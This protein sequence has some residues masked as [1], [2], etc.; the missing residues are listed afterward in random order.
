MNNTWAKSMALAVAVILST[1][2]CG[3]GGDGEDGTAPDEG[4]GGA[5]P[6]RAEVSAA[7]LSV[8]DLTGYDR[9]TPDPEA[10]PPDGSDKPR[11]VNALNDLDYGTPASGTAVQ[12]RAEF[13]HSALG[14]WI[15]QT[16][17]VYRDAS[18][19]EEA[20]ER[21][22]ADLSDCA[23]FTI[24]WSDLARTGTETLRETTR[25]E[26]GDRSWAADIGVE[27]G[28]FPSGETK[29]LV[30]QGRLLIVISHAGAPDAPARK[31][32]EDITRRATQRALRALDDG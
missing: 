3:G 26:L 8:D 23:R 6:T 31:D 9:I 13:G 19:A 32:T 18:A 20:Y 27:L 14:P 30:Q 1:G 15:R 2:A 28:G 4:K 22:V 24:T 29:T 21:T 10:V 25:P 12:G 16:L 7:L 5:L 11:C 17:R